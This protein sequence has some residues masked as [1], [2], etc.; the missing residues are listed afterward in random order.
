MAQLKVIEASDALTHL[1][2]S[3]RLDVA[4]VNAVELQFTTQAT[5][6]RKNTLVDLSELE[7]IASLGM[8]MLVGTAKAL[9]AHNLRLVIVAPRQLVERAL[10]ASSLDEVMPIAKDRDEA[11]GLLSV[12]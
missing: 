12:D 3:G 8:G 6:R 7:F 9:H 4:G 2:V 5:A 1:A 11:M 10:R